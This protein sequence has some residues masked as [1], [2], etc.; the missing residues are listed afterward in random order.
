MERDLSTRLGLRF[1]Y[2]KGIWTKMVQALREI[3]LLHHPL[4]K[5]RFQIFQRQNNH[6]DLVSFC[7]RISRLSKLANLEARLTNDEILVLAVV[8]GMRDDELRRKLFER[9]HLKKM[10]FPEVISFGESITACQVNLTKN[11]GESSV[12]QIGQVPRNGKKCNRCKAIGNI[13]K[14]CIRKRGSL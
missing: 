8:L 7:T 5:R 11:Q 10:S 4:L 13:E 14:D 1:S 6:E 12:S 3:F 2:T 9:Y